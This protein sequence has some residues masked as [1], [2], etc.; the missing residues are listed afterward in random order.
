LDRE[1][2]SVT[3]ITFN[4]EKNI[5]DCLESVKW[6]DEIVV[7]DSGS[8]DKTVEICKDFTDRIFFHPWI[9][10]KEQ[11]QYAVN[12]ASNSW[13][14]SI[15]ADE[16]LTDEIKVFI[17]HELKN[18]SHDGYRFPRQNYFLG[19]WMKHGGWYPDMVLRFFNKEKGFFGGINPHDKV[20]VNSGSIKTVP[21][22]IIH[23]TYNSISQ[24]LIKQNLY[25][26][27]SAM[28]RVKA[29]K[30]V[31]PILIPVK[32]AWKF[33]ETYFMKRGIMDGF[34]GFV[35]AMGST[36]STFLKYVKIWE[37]SGRRKKWD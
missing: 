6:A 12:K 16:R 37:L 30:K 34:H 5:K 21:F 4:E 23:K 11:K 27:V 32:T 33:V 14:F 15:D 36:Y 8:A 28:E 10:M 19:R 2:I 24:Y 18:P 9:G 7:V 26:S 17:I 3:V 22:P 31:M 20:I 29:G 1:K 25:S 35:A 13:I